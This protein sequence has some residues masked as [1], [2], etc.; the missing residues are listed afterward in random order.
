MDELIYQSA[1]SIA[2]AIQDKKVSSVEAVEVHLRRIEEVNPRLNAVVQ[3]CADR[4]LSE[5]READEAI[6]RG[7]TKGALHGV[8]ITLKDSHNTEGVV[9]TGGTK[10][11]TSFVPDKDSIVAARLRGAGAILLGK[12]N[13]PELTMSAETDNLI[14]GTTNNPY[15]VART[16]G[17]SS[18]GAGAII[19]SGGS[20]LD[21][22]SDTGGSIRY[23]AHFCGIA[24]LKPTSG[25]VPRTGHIVP[26]GLGAT[27]AF[28][29]IGPMSRFVE[30]LILALPIVSGVDWRDPAMVPMSIGNPGDVNLHSLRVAVYTDNG[31]MTPTQETIDAVNS[32]AKALSDAG[33]SV[34]EDMPSALNTIGDLP[35][36]VGGAD[37]RAWTRRL[38]ERA[39]TSE[40][41]PNL[42]RRL[43]ASEAVSSEEFSA[44]LEDL[45]RFRS[46][47]IGFME[48][49]DIILAPVAAFPAL[50]HGGLLDDDHKDGMTYC[51]P[52]NMTGWPGAVVRTGPGA[53]SGNSR[54]IDEWFFPG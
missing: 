27:D 44:A 23:P 3:L 17:G 35:S 4:A 14:Y 48:N 26:Y 51:A 2:Q 6:S 1:K 37:G 29:T 7:E 46:E 33:T 24:G 11:R 32:A 34:S 42:K 9:T 15:N 40:V 52:Y 8:P 39:G 47:M 10:G 5:A 50:P 30:D 28:T 25:R 20:P 53:S 43:D 41:H 45:D 18:G 12:T 54:D 36:S 31:K 22:G 38:L 19:A 21:M 49:Y 16:P 13:T